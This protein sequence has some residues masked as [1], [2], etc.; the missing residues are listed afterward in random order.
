MFSQLD[1]G[2]IAC[3]VQFNWKRTLG[4]LHL[5]SSRLCPMCLF[6]FANCALCPFYY[7]KSQ[8]LI[9]LYAESYESFQQT[10]KTAMVL[11]T[12]N[13]I[14]HTFPHFEKSKYSILKLIKNLYFILCPLYIVIHQVVQAFFFFL[15]L[16]LPFHFHHTHLFDFFLV[17]TPLITSNSDYEN[18]L[19][20][21]ALAAI[22]SYY[23]LVV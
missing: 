12:L 14:T 13:T 10:T 8:S 1:A 17:A 7:N 5:D 4:S 20:Q 23:R 21:S 16:S 19:S 22:T 11:R 18:G 15:I 6:P 3:L 2:G 9:G